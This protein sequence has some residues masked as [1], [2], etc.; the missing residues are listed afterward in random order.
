MTIDTTAA[1]SADAGVN[2]TTHLGYA[3]LSIRVNKW[4]VDLETSIV[5]ERM[6]DEDYEVTEFSLNSS[7]PLIIKVWDALTEEQ[8]DELEELAKTAVISAI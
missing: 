3:T 1:I 6:P 2:S 4:P 8:R 5:L 7:D